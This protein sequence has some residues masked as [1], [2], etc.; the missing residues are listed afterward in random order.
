MKQ[1][2]HSISNRLAFIVLYLIIII[3]S[4]FIPKVAANTAMVIFGFVFM[5]L[6]LLFVIFLTIKFKVYGYLKFTDKLIIQGG[7]L[8]KHKEFDYRDYTATIGNYTS[9]IEN[10][11]AL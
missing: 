4:C 5:G 2:M 3:F 10:K 8:C 11:K 7:F 1:S 6:M 9:I